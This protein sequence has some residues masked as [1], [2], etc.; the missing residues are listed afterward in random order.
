MHRLRRWRTVA[1]LTVWVIAGCTRDDATATRSGPGDFSQYDSVGILVSVTA[2]SLARTSLG[3]Q[4]DS[5]PD[6]ELGTEEIAPHEFHRIAGVRQLSSGH[7]VV[8][9]GGDRGLRFFDRDG[10][11]VHRT[12][13]QGRGPGE[14]ETPIL[15]PGPGADSLLVWDV[16]FVRLHVYSPDGRAHR[17]IQ[18]R[19]WAGGRP[20]LGVAGAHGLVSHSA[21]PVLVQAGVT[22]EPGVWEQPPLV[23]SWIDLV[24]GERIRLDSMLVRGS[25]YDVSPA[26]V[27]RLSAIP[28][29]P[30][31]SA[32]V[33]GSHAWITDGGRAEIRVYNLDPR[34][35]RVVRLD[36]ARRPVTDQ[37][38]NG[39]IDVVAGGSSDAR[40]R[41]RR[42]YLEMPIPDSM[43][44]FESLLVDDVGLVWAAVF[45][46]DP[47]VPREW[48]VFDDDGR[49]LGLV[50]TPP[51]LRIHQIG[52]DFILGVARDS[53]DV[54]RVERYGLRRGAAR[55]LAA[56]APGGW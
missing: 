9:D 17:L 41:L 21:S 15:V 27:P 32:A 13:R 48:I 24:S 4:V 33:Q 16:R 56:P 40:E 37:D 51:G 29:S 35:T 55:S 53:L 5:A 28:F 7:V 38:L 43:P 34:L 8:L 54:E 52:V 18:P 26:G 22:Q 1:L 50:A 45:N 44:S 49:A 19:S 6:F 3:W 20:P 39:H 31:P 10:R 42:S 47:A 36:E 11:I 2:G 46:W 23:Y 30:S 14:F 12:G 25:Y